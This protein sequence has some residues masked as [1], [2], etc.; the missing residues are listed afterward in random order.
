MSTL[1]LLIVAHQPSENTRA[2]ADATLAGARHEE[3]ESVETKLLKPLDATA[4]DVM[5]ADGVIIGSTE[6]FGYMGGLVK[7]FLERIYYPCFQKTEG[8]P[9]TL[10]IR[11]GN[12][13]LGAKTSIERIITG[14]KWKLVQEPIICSGEFQQ[15]F[16]DQCTELGMTMAVGLETGVF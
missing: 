8:L 1:Y 12:D 10:Y 4:D 7:D 13:G 16:I 14:L 15:S 11:A 3:I 5:W 6:N 9:Y 2:M